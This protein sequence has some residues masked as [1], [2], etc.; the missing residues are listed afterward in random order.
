[1]DRLRALSSGRFWT[2]PVLVYGFL[3]VCAAGGVILWPRAR[4]E[5]RDNACNGHLYQVGFWLRNYLAVHGTYPRS[6]D[7][8]AT[9]APAVSWR[10]LV[11]I[12]TGDLDGYSLE[13]PW[14][15]PHNQQFILNSSGKQ[16]Q[17]PSDFVAERTGRISYL[18]IVGDGTIWSEVR[19]GHIRSPDKEVPQKIVVIEVPHSDVYWTEPRDISADQA[20]L[21]FR[22]ENGLRDCRHRRGLHYLTADG[23]VH[24]FDEIGGVEEFATLIR[25]PVLVRPLTAAPK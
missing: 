11:T 14:N 6:S 2:G 5:G 4:E 22:L 23:T 8:P 21:L 25:A 20:I 10:V 1:M 7:E 24:C 18:A 15:S 17:C 16:F 3:L 13:E 12:E 9:N 19:L